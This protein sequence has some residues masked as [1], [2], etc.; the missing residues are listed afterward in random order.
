MDLLTLII[1][2]LILG[3]VGGYIAGFLGIGSGIL[4]VPAL[5][6]IMGKNIQEAKACSLFA[7]TVL[8]PIA[9]FRHSR[10][11][12]LNM[13]F[14]LTLGIFGLGGGFGGTVVSEYVYRRAEGLL[15]LLFSLALIVTAIRLIIK[16]EKSD[17]V[18]KSYITPFIGFSAGFVAGL[19]GIGGGIIMVPAMVFA[20]MSIHTAIGTSLGAMFFNAFAGTLTHYYYNYL[21]WGIAVPLAFGASLG[22]EFGVVTANR[23]KP[24][25]LKKIFAFGLILVSLYTMLKGL[26]LLLSL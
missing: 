4:L 5:M 23:T 13:R 2:A 26:I 20:G 16:I 14:A 10:F 25:R 11:E 7:I 24:F 15:L 21:I 3:M 17:R 18:I 12:H 8:S 6:F 19:L 22:V 9:A 1:L